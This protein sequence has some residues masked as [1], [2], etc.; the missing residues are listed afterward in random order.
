MRSTRGEIES[1]SG[2]TRSAWTSAPTRATSCSMR[3]RV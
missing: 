2:A 3:V 1:L